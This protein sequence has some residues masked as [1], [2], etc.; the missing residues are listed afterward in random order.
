MK[1]ENRDEISGQRGKHNIN[2]GWKPP[3]MYI[4]MIA[5][6]EQRQIHDL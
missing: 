3:V 4:E 1:N 2:S 5:Y 6:G